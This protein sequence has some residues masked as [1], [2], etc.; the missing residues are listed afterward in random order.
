MRL[1]LRGGS[2]RLA[3]YPLA[4]EAVLE[5]PVTAV[6]GHS[7]AG[8]TTL[9]ELIAG[10]RA[11]DEGRI[12]FDGDV[13]CDT[14][15]RL[16]MPPRLRRIG[17]VPQDDTLFPHLSVT[18]NLT[19]GRPGAG[20][21]AESDDSRVVD[22]LELGSVLDR[23]TSKLSGGE[24]R[25]VAIGRAILSKPR[26]LLCDEPLTGLDREL[27][28]RI[29][30][31]LETIKREFAIPMIYVAHDAAE[32]RALADEVIVLERGKVALGGAADEEW[33]RALPARPASPGRI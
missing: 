7:G 33:L 23:G 22:V 14:A 9:L 30:R 3:E 5:G 8:K 2:L 27:K 15:D 4:L 28:S 25:R 16:W 6:V 17:Y 18:R 12:E 29:L 31:Y 1:R 20:R 24:R 11:P 10:L 13:F 26:L 21:D 32:V 19:Y